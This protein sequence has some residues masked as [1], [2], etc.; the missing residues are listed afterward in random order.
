MQEFIDHLDAMAEVSGDVIRPYFRAAPDTEY[1]ADASP[2]TVADKAAE[3]AIRGYLETHRPDD[4]IIGEEF[5]HHKGR[6]GLTWVID[7][8]DGTKPFIAGRATF[9]T[10][11][12]LWE[13]DRPVA[14]LIH[15]P[16][17]NEKW[18]GGPDIGTR[19]NG[20]PVACRPC[21][22]LKNARAGSTSPDQFREMPG[23]RKTLEDETAFV[24]W[25][26]DCYSYGLLALGGLDLVCEACLKVHDYAAL[27]PVVLGAGGTMSDFDG[28]PL[29][30]ESDGRVIASGDPRIHD[31]FVNRVSAFR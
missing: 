14:G 21:A 5:G 7:P 26:G 9:G 12:G 27:V 22:A 24:I 6:S 10:L 3:Q 1:K 16:I 13:G 28:N 20:T 17:L 29:T 23:I 4:G 18:I 30:L 25:G 15:Q 8:I 19:F 11:I 2:V 31:E